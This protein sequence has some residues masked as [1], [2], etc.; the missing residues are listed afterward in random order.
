MTLNKLRRLPALAYWALLVSLLGVAAEVTFHFLPPQT[1]P[2]FETWF[3]NLSAADRDF[4]STSIELIAHFFIGLGLA[5]MI[6]AI[7]QQQ[8]NAHERDQN[9]NTP[10]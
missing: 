5:G 3:R 10:K 4:F 9:S 2:A 6:T 7:A 1:I 8:L